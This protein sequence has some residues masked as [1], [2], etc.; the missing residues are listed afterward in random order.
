MKDPLE[1]ASADVDRRGATYI[2]LAIVG[3]LI[4]LAIFKP[5]SR[6]VLALV[7]GIIAMIMLHEAG[8]F[9]AAR[10]AG[11]KA[12]EFFVGFGPRL[13]SFRRGETEFGVKAIPAGGYVR[14][15]GMSNLEDVDPADEPR[16]YRNGT[17]KNRLVVVMAGVTVNAI[18][19]FF[20]FYV[21]IAGQGRVAEGPSTT[22]A[23]ITRGSAA[24]DAGL[25]NGDTISAVDG[26]TIEGWEQLKRAIQSRGGE[27]ATFTVERNDR[28]V[29]LEATPENRD[30][31]GFLGIAP[32]TQFRSV[33][34]LAAVPETFRA[35]GD[36]TVG[37]AEGLADLF[38][39]SGVAEYS[40]NFTGGAPEPGT[41]EADAR[42]RSLVGIVDE[43]SSIIDGNVWALLWLLGGISLILAL[44]NTIPLLPFDGGHAAVVVYEW[45]AS[46]ITRRDVRV[47]YRKLVP[48]I[49]VVLFV[50]LT[51]GLSAMFLDIRQAVGN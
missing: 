3:G 16:A 9:I 14:I 45:V 5:S 2:L 38:S 35:M 19:A 26:Q 22:V 32:T 8:H 1:D 12:S 39:P 6:D 49:A 25:R 21:V 36:I 37:T 11:M 47:D 43:G 51:L 42:P 31:E 41:P 33:G 23:Q 40:K 34:V 29:E 15:L 46:K 27:T 17:T 50:F 28:L 30:G 7:V 10:R 20:L 13:W 4:A 48:M 24:A 44:F 18:L